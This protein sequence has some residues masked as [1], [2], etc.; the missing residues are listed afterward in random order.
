[1]KENKPITNYEL[2]NDIMHNIVDRMKELA[3]ESKHTHPIVSKLLNDLALD[4]GPLVNDLMDDG[5]RLC[6]ER[7]DSYVY[8][9]GGRIYDRHKEYKR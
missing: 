1:M 3:T 8:F 6:P 4:F 9:D 7:E 2:G 5:I